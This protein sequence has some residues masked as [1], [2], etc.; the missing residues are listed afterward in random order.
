MSDT[1]IN[2]KVALI[3]GAS[4]GI[5]AATAILFARLGA[6]LSLTGRKEDNLKRI[7]DECVRVSPSQAE[8]PLMILADLR[9]EAEVA[10]IVDTT[11]AKFGRLDVLVN[12][13]GI[14]EFGSIESTSMEQY[15]RIMNINV[16][17]VYHLTMLCVPH[18]IETRGNIVN[19]SSIAGARS[20]S[21]ILA[22]CMSKSATDQMTSCTA[23]E[24]ASKG[25]RVNSVNPGV[26]PTNIHQRGGLIGDEYANY[27]ERMKE[28]H[29]LGRLGDPDEVAQAIA[30]LASSSASFITGEQF[31]VDAGM[32][33]VCAR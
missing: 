6:K 1:C 11:I 5:G 16:R 30:F 23:L 4:S 20:F 27:M 25:V 10:K 9:S 29:P 15:D 13:A 31:H 7:V 33:A 28:T 21:G 32:H 26:V 12:N 18:L 14:I 3:T 2:G 8:Q 17:A 24:L 22:Y 19:V